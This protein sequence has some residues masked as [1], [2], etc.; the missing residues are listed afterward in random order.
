MKKKLYNKPKII[1]QKIR[2]NFFYK[3]QNFNDEILLANFVPYD[4][5]SP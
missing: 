3:Y 2:V 1:K 5:V 4:P